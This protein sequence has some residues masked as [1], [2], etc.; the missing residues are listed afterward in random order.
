M[1]YASPVEIFCRATA[2]LL[3]GATSANAIS[4]V[5]EGMGRLFFGALAVYTFIGVPYGTDGELYV[6]SFLC[7][8]IM[9][10]LMAF[11]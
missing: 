2:W 7:T 11:S 6:K 1:Q 9:F 3:L 10:V 5:P 8:V 4:Y